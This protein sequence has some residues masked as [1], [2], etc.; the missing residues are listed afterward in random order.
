MPTHQYACRTCRQLSTL[1]RLRSRRRQ[2]RVRAV[3]QPSS[4]WSPQWTTARTP[5]ATLLSQPDLTYLL[6]VQPLMRTEMPL[7]AEAGQK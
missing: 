6:A 1:K 3:S 4:L 7:T 5:T 2:R